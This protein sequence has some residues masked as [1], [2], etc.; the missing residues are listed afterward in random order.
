VRGQLC[1]EELGSFAASGGRTGTAARGAVPGT[2]WHSAIDLHGVGDEVLVGQVHEQVN[3]H[4]HLP[5]A[6]LLL[7]WYAP[8]IRGF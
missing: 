4:V 6:V 1:E 3:H 5:H 7:I 2:E 8:E